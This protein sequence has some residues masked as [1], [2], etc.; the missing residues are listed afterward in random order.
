M[1][2]SGRSILQPC[3][4]ESC[5][6]SVRGWNRI[7]RERAVW[8]RTSQNQRVRSHILSVRCW[9]NIIRIRYSGNILR[10]RTHSTVSSGNATPVF[11][12][13]SQPAD[14]SMNSG[15]GMSEPRASIA[16]RAAYTNRSPSQFARTESIPSTWYVRG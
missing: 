9:K 13:V 16:R 2:R 10:S 8:E 11:V 1:R 14:R 12:K 7:S 15:L 3:V 6:P 5:N 4:K